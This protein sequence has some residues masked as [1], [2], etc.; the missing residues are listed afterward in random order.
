MNTDVYTEYIQTVNSINVFGYYPTNWDN[1]RNVLSKLKQDKIYAHCVN[2]LYI[3]IARS[4]INYLAYGG[5]DKDC[6]GNAGI[7]I[8]QQFDP[9]DYMDNISIRNLIFRDYYTNKYCLCGKEGC[10]FKPPYPIS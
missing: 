9:P 10:Q 5:F 8:I 7:W 2:S 4:Y 6:L 1:V 3:A